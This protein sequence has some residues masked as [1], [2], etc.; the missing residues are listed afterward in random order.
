MQFR[1]LKTALFAL[2]LFAV[3]NPL[4]A[5]DR[6]ITVASTTSTEQSGL[7]D[8]LLPI[9][10]KETG[11]AVHVVAVGTGQALSIGERGDADALLVHDRIGEDKFVADGF[12]I[13][14]RDVMFND[15]V[16]IGPAA[17]PA[18]IRD[19]TDVAES[20]RRIAQ[21]GAPFAS[22][23]DDSG[24]NRMELRLWKTA[25]VDV[26]TTGAWYRDL[27]QG[28]G[29]TLNT[30][31]AM[32]AYTLSDRATWANFKN[33][34]SLTILLE[35]DKRLLNPYATILV[36]PAKHASVKTGDAKIWH[37]WLTSPT[38]QSAIA[39]YRVGNEQLFFPSAKP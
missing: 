32:N 24:T 1:G 16:I 37:D 21:S 18:K 20:F 9:F 23:G 8:Y 15:F 36:N 14:R 39:G 30:A 17:D 26:K 28:M 6:F 13:D 10:T 34:Q 4:R 2:L 3:A 12:G 19:T 22:R 7:F 11:I 35:G 31:A 33:R 29:P 27:G 25:G 5:E 38:G